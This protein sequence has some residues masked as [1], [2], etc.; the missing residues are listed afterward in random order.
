MQN[1]AAQGS[2]KALW[3]RWRLSKPLKKVWDLVIKR[4][5]KTVTMSAEGKKQK[6]RIMYRTEL[7]ILKKK[8]E[9]VAWTWSSGPN[10][11]NPGSM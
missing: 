8:S 4:T 3:K 1:K 10:T 6:A 5:Q 9:E 11:E 2:Q 7:M